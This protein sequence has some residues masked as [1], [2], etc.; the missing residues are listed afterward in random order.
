M[1]N[2]MFHLGWTMIL[3]YLVNAILVVSLRVFLGESLI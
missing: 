3:R 1:V 2:F